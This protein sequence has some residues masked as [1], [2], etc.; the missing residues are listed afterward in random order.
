MTLT[1]DEEAGWQQFMTEPVAYTE[2]SR[3]AACLKIPVGLGQQLLGTPRLQTRLSSVINDFYKLTWIAPDECVSSDR[4]IALSSAGTLWNFVQRAGA[5]YWSGTMAGAVL[6][7]DVQILQDA[8]GAELYAFGL[9]NRDLSG[10]RQ[11][12]APFDTL[13]TRIFDDG[14]RCFSAW[15]NTLPQ[16]VAQ[17]VRLKLATSPILDETPS[18]PFNTSGPEIVRRAAS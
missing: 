5:I 18:S 9:K 8:L 7:K 12:L 3:L 6:T 17:R 16:G 15:C 11:D 13:A 14:W 2:G 1:P 4:R 10:A